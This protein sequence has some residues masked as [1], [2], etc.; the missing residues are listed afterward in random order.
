M[1][2]EAMQFDVGDTVNLKSGGPLM[3]VE[4]FVEESYVGCVWF[5]E[6]QIQRGTFPAAT[7]DKASAA[8]RAA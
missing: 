6:H 1:M 8:T 2:E 3:T 5:E 4:H 7:L